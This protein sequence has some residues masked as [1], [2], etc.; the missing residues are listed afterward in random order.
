MTNVLRAALTERDISTNKIHMII[1]N[2]Q[3]HFKKLGAFVTT[4]IW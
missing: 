4:Y 2:V 3:E 1:K